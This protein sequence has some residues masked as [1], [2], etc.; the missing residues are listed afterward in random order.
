VDTEQLADIEGL[1]K[2]E[3]IYSS[4][5]ENRIMAYG[6]ARDA[7]LS[8]APVDIALAHPLS[9]TEVRAVLQGLHLLY[10]GLY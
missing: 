9:D 3:D 1:N 5:L 7:G 6:R 8:I 4:L 10:R 2:Q